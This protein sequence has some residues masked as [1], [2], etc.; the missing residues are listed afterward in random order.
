MQRQL[1]GFPEVHWAAVPFSLIRP[2]NPDKQTD[3]DVA[4]LTGVMAPFFGVEPGKPCGFLD[5]PAWR[6]LQND[7][8]WTDNTAFFAPKPGALYPAVYDLAER[9]LAA[10]KST[11]AFDQLEQ[12]GWRDSL[13][14]E[15][16]WLSLKKEELSTTPGRRDDTL[17]ARVA[18]N[19][20]AWAKE[21]E[22]LGALSAIK[23]LWPTIFAEEVRDALG[24]ETVPRFVVSTHTMAL[25]DQ[26]DR[27][28]ERG[29]PMTEEL[30]KEL[31][32]AEPVALPRRL[33]MRH[34]GH[35]ELDRAK[36][37]PDLLERAADDLD[38]ATT[39]RVQSLIRRALA[40]ERE[41]GETARVETYYALLMM[42]GDEMGA[43]L[44]GGKDSAPYRDCFHPT[45]RSGFDKRADRNQ[46]I[47][48]Y[49]RQTRAVSP[50][51]H[52]AISAA[53]N[54]FALHAVPEVIESEHAGRVVY[55]GGDDVVAM[56]PV[57]DLIPAMQ[58]LRQAYSG[59]DSSSANLDWRQ[60]RRDPKLAIKDGFGLLRGRLLLRLMGEKATASCGAVI[61]HHQAPLAAV[62]RELR[63][64]EHRAKT[65]GRRDAWSLALIKRSGGTVHLTG[66]W[67]EPLDALEALR[68]FLADRDVSRRAV[69]NTLEWIEELPP[70]DATLLETLL[71]YQLKRQAES[72]S[73]RNQVPGLAQQV[74]KVAFDPNLR[75]NDAKPVDWLKNFLIGAEFLAREVRR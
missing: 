5:S 33:M 62:L 71:A 18:K 49:G 6:V 35:P 29:S 4:A 21:G 45:V 60:A 19:K 11:H 15:S 23:R 72:E 26:L 50:N 24:V 39:R 54:D 46:A 47:N 65:E 56:L 10:A 48:Q 73:A 41:A 22:H 28:L 59:H 67:G 43:W 2:R 30:R 44:S 74:V 7:I 3:L 34:R 12:L 31:E 14:G 40:P 17:W 66:K 57:A 20:P 64:A 37:L 38:E 42:D 25:A 27:W 61:A 55:A 8:R 9:A 51:R 58:R 32:R 69:Y 36:C 63:A 75:P 1:E 16:E 53:L 52:L 70:L 68:G 13:T